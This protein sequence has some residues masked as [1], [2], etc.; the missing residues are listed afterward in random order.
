MSGIFPSAGVGATNA[1]NSVPGANVSSGCSALWYPPRCNPRFD[2]AQANAV[3]SEIVN[4][5][6]CAGLAYDCSR[7]DNLCRA[8]RIPCLTELTAAPALGVPRV[9]VDNT[10]TPALMYFWDCT[11]NVYRPLDPSVTGIK[12][13]SEL[14]TAPAAGVPRTWIDDTGA[15]AEF[16]YWDCAA[17]VYRRVSPSTATES[18]VC[19]S[20]LATAPANGVPRM[21]IDDS[22]NPAVVTYWDCGANVYRQITSGTS[23]EAVTTV[24]AFRSGLVEGVLAA[25][26]PEVALGGTA[27]YVLGAN[28]TTAPNPK[29][30]FTFTTPQADTNYQVIGN[31]LRYDNTA[32]GAIGVKENLFANIVKNANITNK[33]VNGFTLDATGMM[34]NTVGGL[35]GFWFPEFDIQIVR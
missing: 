3:I 27:T 9:F 7:L 23:A 1:T 17:A 15:I 31:F 8:L 14:T 24:A 16:V 28:T 11:S 35:G 32:S 13:R 10:V 33:T 18:V 29:Y 25:P 30:N 12:C 2:P 6:N 21:Y 20:Q 26:T 4:A 22:V 19:R 5:V 34:N